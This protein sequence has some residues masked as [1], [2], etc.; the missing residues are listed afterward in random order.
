MDRSYNRTHTDIA[1]CQINCSFR[2]ACWFFSRERKLHSLAVSVPSNILFCARHR[3]SDGQRVNH[4]RRRSLERFPLLTMRAALDIADRPSLA[5]RLLA[6]KSQFS[7]N[8]LS[9]AAAGRRSGV[10]HLAAHPRPVGAMSFHF[11]NLLASCRVHCQ[12][13]DCRSPSLSL[14]LILRRVY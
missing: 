8:V 2:G 4:R 13:S 1:R 5:R 7:V 12:R 14:E 10:E 6:L 11:P 9:H 3:A